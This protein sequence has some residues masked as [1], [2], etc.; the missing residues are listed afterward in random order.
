[1]KSKTNN[2]LYWISTIIFALLMLMDG[3]GGIM[4]QQAGKDV[5]LKLGYP[6]YFLVIGGTAKILGAI[7]LLQPWYKTI[8][9]WAFA[10]FAINFICASVS[11]AISGGG[12]MEIIFPLIILLLMFIPYSAWKKKLQQTSNSGQF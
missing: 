7:A 12:L 8:K 6:F 11:W 4:Q 3:I 9:E 5:M 2:N 10:G 1:M